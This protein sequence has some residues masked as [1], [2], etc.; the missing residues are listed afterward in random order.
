MLKLDQKVRLTYIIY[1]ISDPTA[2]FT[3]DVF[4]VTDTVALAGQV[5]D[6]TYRLTPC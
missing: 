3:I 2:P 1:F 5:F 6:L 4:S